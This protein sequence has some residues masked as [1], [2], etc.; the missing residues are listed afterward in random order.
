M[1]NAPRKTNGATARLAYLVVGT[2][3]ANRSAKA[4]HT[5][6]HHLIVAHPRADELE[7]VSSLSLEG[8]PRVGLAICDALQVPQSQQ[9]L[10]VA[11]R[12]LLHFEFGA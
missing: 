3:C 1:G 11:L 10:V 4:P 7:A 6:V 12:R 5:R 2:A 8:W 9:R